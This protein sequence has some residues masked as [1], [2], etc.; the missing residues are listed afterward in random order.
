MNLSVEEPIVPAE[1]PVASG[2]IEPV[3]RPVAP[4]DLPFLRRLYASTRREELALVPWSDAQK[5][6]FLAQQFAAQD[7]HYRATFPGASFLV[8]EV[9]GI[10]AGRVTLDRGAGE[11][12]LIDIALLPGWRGLGIG[13]RLLAGLVVEAEQSGERIRLHVEKGNA[14]LRFYLRHR[15]QVVGETGFHLE[16]V[17]CPS[18]AGTVSPRI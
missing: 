13:S 11:V 17:R 3:T 2:P 1:C 8:V 6:Q 7:C 12:R 9:D 16:M 18:S 10:P 14:A 15:F 4:G 5:D